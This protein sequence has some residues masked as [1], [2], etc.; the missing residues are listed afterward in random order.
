MTIALRMI[1]RL[2]GPSISSLYLTFC[3]AL[4]LVETQEGY[5]HYRADTQHEE[6]KR[7]NSNSSPYRLVQSNSRPQ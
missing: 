1:E 2:P 7:A 6:K 5:G 3:P 4:G